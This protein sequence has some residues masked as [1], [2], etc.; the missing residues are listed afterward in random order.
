[1]T[2]QIIKSTDGKEEY[3]LLPITAY[4]VLKKEIDDVLES[5]FLEYDL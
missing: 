3:V 5:D 1:M 4:R 2:L